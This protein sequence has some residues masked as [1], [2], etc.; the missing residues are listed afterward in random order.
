[1]AEFT[2][3]KTHEPTARRRQQARE[4]GQVAQSHDLGFAVL[5]LGSLA[6]LVF[7]GAALVEFLA[8]LLKAQLSGGAWRSWLDAR[9]NPSELAA[10]QWNAVLPALG[11]LLL[12]ILAGAAAIA[13]VTGL[14][15]TGF[16][17]R[18]ARIAPDFSRVNPFAGLRRVFSGGSGARLLLGLCKLGAVVGVGLG[19]LWSRREELAA[20]AGLDVPQI[21][22][23]TWEICF[24][25]GLEIAGALVALA[26]VDYL[27]QRMKLE[28]DLRMSPE[29][30]R[31]E[32][33]EMQGDPQIASR[34]RQLRH[35]VSSAAGGGQPQA[36][37]R[38][39]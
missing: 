2:G 22:V 23:R 8:E 25:S 20:L 9:G 7:C 39:A 38:A 26:A 11:R 36:I 17:A 1:M 29:E 12:P 15:Q 6:L 31:Q 32:L 37:D 14:M 16:L 4:T 18:T 10:S 27:Y 19:G 34:R 35:A 33:R 3:D 28:H 5:L 13:L 24:W 30:L 21:A